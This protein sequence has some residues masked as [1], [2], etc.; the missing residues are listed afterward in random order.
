MAAYGCEMAPPVPPGHTLTD[1][2][3]R[4]HIIIIVIVYFIN[5]YRIWSVGR[6]VGSGGFGAIYLC[7]RGEGAA[8]EDSEYVVKIEPHSNGPL[9]VEMHVFMRIGQDDQV[10]SWTPSQSNKPPGWVGMPRFHG[11]GSTVVQGQRLRCVIV[12]MMI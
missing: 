9:F 12:D 1:S 7:D 10:A 2:R 4:Y 6:A 5:Y 11:S 3:Q 8:G